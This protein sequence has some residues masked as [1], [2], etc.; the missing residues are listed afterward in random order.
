MV[1]QMFSTAIFQE[2]LNY[3]NR[4][5]VSRVHKN[6][7]LYQCQVKGKKY[8]HVSILFD[9]QNH[10]INMECDCEEGQRGHYCKHE[11]AVL[12]KLRK[13]RYITTES[14]NKKELLVKENNQGQEDTTLVIDKIRNILSH[15]VSRAE[16]QNVEA[17]MKQMKNLIFDYSKM[18]MSDENQQ[19]IDSLF[20]QWFKKLFR[21]HDNY[22]L[23][24][25]QWVKDIFLNQQIDSIF[26]LILRINDTLPDYCLF[27]L[28]NQLIV[29]SQIQTNQLYNHTI[30]LYIIQHFKRHKS[31]IK[32]T[33]K[34]LPKYSI[35]S[36]YYHIVELM[37]KKKY[38]K[39]LKL[40][41]ELQ[42]LHLEKEIE[43][44]LYLIEDTLYFHNYVMDDYKDYVMLCYSDEKKQTDIHYMKQL[45]EKYGKTWNVEKYKIYSALYQLMDSK[46]FQNLIETMEEWQWLVFYL[47]EHPSLDMFLQYGKM[48]Y[49]HDTENYLFVFQECIIYEIQYMINKQDY[50]KITYYLDEQRNYNMT[51]DKM[52]EIIMNIKNKYPK[53]SS[54]IEVLNQYLERCERIEKKERECLSR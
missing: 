51:W 25:C 20:V 30:S 16:P 37:S 28:Y 12:V 35:V 10:I 14:K 6:E 9:K 43:E 1:K 8:Y 45:Q 33:V 52:R 5:R 34:Q 13:E 7:N 54:L 15:L 3:Y 46:C 11:A 24:Y 26:D 42:S 38:V 32:E 31:D 27:P 2:G 22:K 44:E 17:I 18:T 19:I 36:L 21:K 29:E 4:G 53:R 48:I 23:S 47:L 49:K 39:A 41:R 50:Q 40:Y